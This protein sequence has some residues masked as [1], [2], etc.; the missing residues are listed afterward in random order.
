MIGIVA[1]RIA[2]RYGLPCILISFENQNGTSDSVP[3]PAD[4][5]RGS[6]RSVKGMNLVV[7]CPDYDT[8]HVVPVPVLDEQ[9]LHI[10]DLCRQQDLGH[11]LL[12]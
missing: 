4:L 1:S 8:Y 11:R 3:S 10:T 5:G 7:L 12:G 6:G 9:I 2:E